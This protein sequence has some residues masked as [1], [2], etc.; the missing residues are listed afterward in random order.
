MS[1]KPNKLSKQ[2]QA[3]INKQLTPVYSKVGSLTFFIGLIALLI[4]LWIDRTQ[5]TMPIFTLVCVIVSIP[6]VLFINTRMMRS[7][8]RKAADATK[9]K[10]ESK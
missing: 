1:K 10:T 8:V 7:A 6:L 2:Q 3:T 9:T 5:G 4:G